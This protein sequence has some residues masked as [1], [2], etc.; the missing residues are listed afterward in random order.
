MRFLIVMALAAALPVTASVAQTTPAAMVAGT[1]LDIVSTGEVT[2]IP[3][4]VQIGAGV[5]TQA[6]TAVEALRQNAA[7][8][9]RLR[10]ALTRAGIAAR[11]IQTSNISLQPDYRYEQNQ[12][13]RLIGYRASNQVN[14]RFRNIAE[15]GGILDALVAEGANQINGPNLG[16]DRPEAALDEARVAAL[17]NA[18]ARAELY[19]R[20]LN[21]RVRRVLLVSEAGTVMPPPMPVLRMRG[22]AADGPETQIDP[23]EQSLSVTLT[24][25][26]EL[27]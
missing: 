13:P 15:S 18:R 1:R 19:A 12:P 27:E 3:D 22:M 5:V 6:P 23:G 24:V 8:M 9:E 26:F 4:I 14:V 17:A 16:I 20:S 2:R 11:D 21:M 25:S 7:R 10:A